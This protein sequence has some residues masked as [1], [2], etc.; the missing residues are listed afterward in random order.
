MTSKEEA[1]FR[2][3]TWYHGTTLKEWRSICQS[4]ILADFNIGYSLDFGN[5]FYLSPNERDTQKY[6]LDTV[7]YNGSDL[8]EDNIPVVLVFNYCPIEDINNG[9]SYK[10]FP[11]YD[12]EFSL[13]VFECRKNYLGAKTHTFDITG[14]VMTDTIPTVI[15]QQFF[16]NQITK[17][18]VLKQF[19][20]STSKKQL[21]L[22][23]QKLCDKLKLAKAYIVNGKELDINEYKK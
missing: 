20:K 1:F 19:Q 17:E 23:T 15:M 22:H 14:G 7:K 16:V 21:C 10:Y 9:Y 12:E 3:T 13:F 18:D 4:K 8:P 5:G 6:A 2:I 11:K